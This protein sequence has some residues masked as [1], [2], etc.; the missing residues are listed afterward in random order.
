MQEI[1]T[2]HQFPPTTSLHCVISIN[3]TGEIGEQQVWKIN[4]KSTYIKEQLS[5]Q[6]V[7]TSENEVCS[8]IKRFSFV[9][10]G[11]SLAGVLFEPLVYWDITR[12]GA[13]SWLFYKM[14]GVECES[15]ESFIFVYHVSAAETDGFPEI[16]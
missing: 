9:P 2:I 8:F 14:L 4:F 16:P 1:I 15:S 12:G 3:P 10:Q 7:A 6:Y 5:E 11:K 13:S